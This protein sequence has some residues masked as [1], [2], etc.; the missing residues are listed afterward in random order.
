LDARAHDF[1]VDDFIEATGPR[2]GLGEAPAAA[3]KLTSVLELGDR[4]VV[5]ELSRGSAGPS[6]R[7]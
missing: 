6:G 3:R 1:R 7:S 4:L 2:T 5:S